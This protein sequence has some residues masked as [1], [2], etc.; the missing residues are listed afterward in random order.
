MSGPTAPK[1]PDAQSAGELDELFGLQT[2]EFPGA[3]KTISKG[4][5]TTPFEQIMVSASVERSGQSYYGLARLDANGNPDSSFGEAGYVYG[6]FGTPLFSQGGPLI[7]GADGLIWMCGVIGVIEDEIIELQ[8]V[9]ARFLPDGSLDEAFGSDK[10]GYQIVPMRIPPLSGATHGR[11]ILAKSTSTVMAPDKLLFVSS[12]KGSGLLTRL[13][14]DGSDDTSF[15]SNGWLPLTLPGVNISLLGIIQLSDGLILV[16]GKIEVT[17]QGLVMAFDSSGNVAQ[18]FGDK[19]VLVLNIQR[20]GKPLESRVE[21]IIER[22]AQRLLLLGSANESTEGETLQHAFI[23]GITNVGKMDETFNDKK[24]V[25]TPA[26]QALD[27][28]QWT[29][30]FTLDDERIVTVGQT[31]GSAR[32]LLT[33]GFLTDGTVDI[34]FDVEGAKDISWTAVDA[35]TQGSSILILGRKDD[36][37]QLVRLLTAPVTTPLEI[38]GR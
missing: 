1:S 24:P 7:V 30:G 25:I 2:L 34:S 12:Q 32:G 27:L 28:K 4:V 5:A 13:E 17:N 22:T 6:Q 38:G 20:N 31:S 15:G 21:K 11:L 23:S 29:A 3:R 9:I 14:L 33:G 35:C 36:S 19:G 37:A 10:N 16:H 26:T 18:T 8:Q